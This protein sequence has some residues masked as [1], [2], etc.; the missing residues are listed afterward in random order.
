[1]F[2]NINQAQWLWY[3]HNAVEDDNAEFDRFRD[4]VEYNASFI[5]PEVVKSIIE[6]RKNENGDGAGA[7][8][9]NTDE[10]FASNIEELFGKKLEI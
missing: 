9:S 5:E 8:A 10:E 7:V 2:D 1:M 3:F 6:D 4:F